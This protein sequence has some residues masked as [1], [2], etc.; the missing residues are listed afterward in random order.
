MKRLAILAILILSTTAV[1]AASMPDFASR[2]LAAHN[3]ERAAVG[4]PPL[5]W[6]DALAADAAPW[7]A[8]LAQAVP[9]QHSPND[10]RLDEGENI[11]RGT[12]GGY[13]LEQMVGGWAAEKR[14]FIPA[15]SRAASSMGR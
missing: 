12:A 8:H 10:D 3:Q 15:C 13:T 1:Q 7:A 5:V 14:F 9:L 2:I 11:W 4:V 6:S